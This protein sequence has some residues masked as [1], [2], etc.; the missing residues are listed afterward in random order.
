MNTEIKALQV[1]YGDCFIIKTFDNK[2]EE[3]NILMDGGPG[4][5]FLAVLK[6]ELQDKPKIDLLIITHIDDDHIK[7]LN[8]FLKSSLAGKVKIEN[9]LINAKNL[10]RFADGKELSYASVIDF[11]KKILKKY[12]DINIYGD[13]VCDEPDRN[14]VLF[15][16][17]S[18]K[19]NILSP[20]RECLTYLYTEEDKRYKV[21]KW[22]DVELEHLKETGQLSEPVEQDEETIPDIYELAQADDIDKNK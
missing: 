9:V 1:K 16:N 21:N 22:H 17:E 5:S 6:R 2:G 4:N 12:P 11:E 3:F 13:C 18:I 15:R 19:I 10:K 14:S 20:N 7:G 8:N